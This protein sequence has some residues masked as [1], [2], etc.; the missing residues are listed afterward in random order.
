MGKSAASIAEVGARGDNLPSIET[1]RATLTL[2][3]RLKLNHPNAVLRR[4][5]ATLEPEPRPSWL[6]L[7][8]A[9]G[10]GHPRRPGRTSRNDHRCMRA[11]V[12]KVSR[13]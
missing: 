12:G 7:L 5:K 11:H 13:N 2:P 9:G 1:W 6:G 10:F 3:E 4:W 8:Y